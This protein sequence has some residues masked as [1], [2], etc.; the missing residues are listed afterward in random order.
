MPIHP[1]QYHPDIN[2]NKYP[3]SMYCCLAATHIWKM[4]SSAS[5]PWLLSQ[6][7][8]DKGTNKEKSKEQDSGRRGVH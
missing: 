1:V 4:A 3:K 5:T 6:A 8:L 2:L 7:E